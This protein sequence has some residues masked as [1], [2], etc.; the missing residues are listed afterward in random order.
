[1]G[2]RLLIVGTGGVGGGSFWVHPEVPAIQ[3][4]ACVQRVLYLFLR[5]VNLQF[6]SECFVFRL[7]GVLLSVERSFN[8]E[9][10]PTNRA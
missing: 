5:G 4:Y 10:I 7:L 1:M 9:R 3:G 6:V 2:W 8:R